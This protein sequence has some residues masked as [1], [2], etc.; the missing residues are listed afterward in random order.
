MSIHVCEELNEITVLLYKTGSIRDSVTWKSHGRQCRQAGNEKKK[1]KKKE[2]EKKKAL[3]VPVI[4]LFD[5]LTCVYPEG[6]A[7][8]LCIS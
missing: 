3:P 8:E 2:R 6:H 7:E 1:K 4:T 5:C